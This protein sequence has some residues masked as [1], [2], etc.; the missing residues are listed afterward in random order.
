MVNDGDISRIS[1]IFCSGTAPGEQPKNRMSRG[2]ADFA[3]EFGPPYV[4]IQGDPNLCIYAPRERQH[5]NAE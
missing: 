3:A 5:Q 2:D 4:V 1:G